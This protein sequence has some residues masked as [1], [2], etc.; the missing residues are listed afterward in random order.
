MPI[1]FLCERQIDGFREAEL[2]EIPSNVF[3]I[4]DYKCLF[5]VAVK[6]NALIKFVYFFVFSARQKHDL[7]TTFCP[8][9]FKSIL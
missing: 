8:C 9:V 5:G 6:P 4:L 3:G 7:V 2:L 1:V